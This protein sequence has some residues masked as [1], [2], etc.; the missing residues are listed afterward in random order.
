M[1]K[2]I[3]TVLAIAI[4]VIMI[5]SI[6][7]GTEVQT[8]SIASDDDNTGVDVLRGIENNDDDWPHCNAS[9]AGGG[10]WFMV[11]GFRNTFGF[12]MND[13]DLENSSFVFQARS[14]MM[15]VHSLNFT[16]IVFEDDDG[17][18]NWTAHAYGNATVKELGK[19]SFH[20]QVADC[21]KG[22][23]DKIDL[24]LES[25]SGSYHW[26]TDSLGGGN[27]WVKRCE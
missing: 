26:G 9:S 7:V 22:N 15:T 10:G 19:F 21:G 11:D 8:N 14:S 17:D 6:M 18:G 4:A 12:C 27:I 16:E 23:T 2:L 5:G 13:S 24:R 20:L 25:D 1:K 3:I